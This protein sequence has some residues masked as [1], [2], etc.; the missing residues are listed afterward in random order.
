MKI[1][2]VILAVSVLLC[3][4]AAAPTFETVADDYM[5][6][7]VLSA[8]KLTFAAPQD[9]SAQVIYGPDGALYFCEGYEIMVQTFA[10]G[11]INRTLQSLTGYDSQTLT[12]METETE[13]FSRYECVWLCAG[14]NGDHIGRCVILD[15]GA[16]HYCLSTMALAEEAGSLQESWQELFASASIQ[17]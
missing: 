2:W 6:G 11:D 17:S 13:D 3:G 9:A 7:Q 1:V 4:C 14:E 12:V 5:G 15:D 8:G 10:A 16:H